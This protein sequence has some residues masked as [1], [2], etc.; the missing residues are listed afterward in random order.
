M[1]QPKSLKKM[2]EINMD[3]A[4][5]KVQDKITFV[6]Q[7]SDM[8]HEYR[9]REM[10]VYDFNNGMRAAELRGI[11]KGIQKGIEKG[12][13]R[14]IEKGI[15][16]GI[17]TAAVNLK[18]AGFSVGEIANFIERTAEETAKILEENGC[19]NKESTG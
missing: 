17:V 16:K 4:I 1:K 10:A 5:K 3:T 9:M 8:L 11:E 14:G 12:I 15:R 19:S 7:D 2:G 13:Q 18:Q 6:A